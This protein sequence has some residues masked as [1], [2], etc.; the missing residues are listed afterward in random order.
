MQR[1][2]E[3]PDPSASSS[4][5]DEAQQDGVDMS[6]LL[7]NL[8]RTVLERIRNHDRA[9]TLALAL[10]QAMT[11]RYGQFREPSGSPD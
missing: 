3:H 7:A 11:D 10:R 8:N 4:A 2:G 9:L 6:G 5:W 1:A